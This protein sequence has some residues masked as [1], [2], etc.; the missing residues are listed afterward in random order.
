[1][2]TPEGMWAMIKYPS[3]AEIVVPA[4]EP[5]RAFTRGK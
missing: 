5:M 3:Y 2:A 1:M 4:K